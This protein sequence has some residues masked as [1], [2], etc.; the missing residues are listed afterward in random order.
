MRR[1][2]TIGSLFLSVSF[3]A[4]VL[5]QEPAQSPTQGSAQSPAQ[6]STQNPPAT[7][8][9]QSTESQI[10]LT[11]KEVK[12]VQH[13]LFSR[14]FLSKEPS[15]KLDADTRQAL[16][17]FQKAQNLEMT[18]R[19]DSPT[20][21]KLEITLPLEQSA[22]DST[23]KGGFVSKLGYGIKDSATSTGKAISNTAS[24][25]GSTT[26]DGTEK[27]ISTSSDAVTKSGSTLANTKDKSVEGAKG[28]GTKISTAVVGRS[29]VEIHKDVRKVLNS[30]EAT[31][32]LQSEVRE[33]KVTLINDAGNENDLGTVVAD[34]RKIPGVKSVVVV[35][36]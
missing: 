2:L 28:A 35:Q 12:A 18:G 34:V 3:S 20:L 31:R 16:R 21:D 14:G 22:G 4:V 6:S 29:D 8:T 5:A 33:G 27:V 24:K 30:N 36:K 7:E 15:G 32:Y 23:R 17:D 11:A 13:A 19:I 25:I 26:K 10:A 1:L 9:Q